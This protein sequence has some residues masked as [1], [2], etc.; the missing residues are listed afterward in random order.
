MRH[1]HKPKITS[2]G[3]RK[4]HNTLINLAVGLIVNE[5]IKTTLTKAKALRGNAERMITRGKQGNLTARRALLKSLK[6]EGAVR[7]L[8]E[9]LGPRYK[10]RRGGYTRIV[11]LGVRKGD[12]APMARVELV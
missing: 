11:K 7:K 2:P 3:R 10:E 6:R 9:E 5:K 8:L 1:R 12:G 4:D